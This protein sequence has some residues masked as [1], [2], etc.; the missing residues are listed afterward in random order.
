MNSPKSI[1]RNLH[2]PGPNALESWVLTPLCWTG[3]DLEAFAWHLN[4]WQ[5]RPVYASAEEMEEKFEKDFL[6]QSP[7][8]AGVILS[9]GAPAPY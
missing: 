8:R 2:S 5:G 1:S 9:R 6:E 3:P 4:H 7:T